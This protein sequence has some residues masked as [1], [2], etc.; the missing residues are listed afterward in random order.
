MKSITASGKTVEDAVKA[1]LKELGLESSD[2]QIDVLDVGSPGLFGMFG[3]LAK[4]RLTVREDEM[5]IEMPVMTLGNKGLSVL[6]EVEK[7]SEKKQEKKAETKMVEEEPAPVAA[8]EAEPA[9]EE[10]AAEP[11]SEKPVSKPAWIEQEEKKAEEKK[12]EA[13]KAEEK[14]PEAKKAPKAR[15]DRRNDRRSD[16]RERPERAER[17]ERSEQRAEIVPAVPDLPPMDLENAGEDEKRAYE[18]LTEVTGKMGVNVDIRMVA[19]EEQLT[20]KMTGDTVGVLIGRRGDTLDALQYLTSLVVNRGRE[21]YLRV[22]LD[23]ENYR[24]RREDAL[25]KLA[26]RMAAKAKRTGRKV[27]LEPMNPY[28]RRI[29]HSALQNNPHVATHSEGEEPYRRVVITLK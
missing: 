19:N 9:I 17:P 7:K 16:R 28:E 22:S 6:G 8:V 26:E 25:T 11:V 4:V 2:V 13:K 1:G 24:A 15:D 10:K 3:R 12:A 21:N 14:K 20:I 27:V 18:F 23:S 5:K 29:L